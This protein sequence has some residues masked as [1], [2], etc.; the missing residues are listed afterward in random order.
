MSLQPPTFEVAG[1]PTSVRPFV[2]VKP[3]NIL[4]AVANTDFWTYVLLEQARFVGGDS[5]TESWH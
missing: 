4:K 2:G 1:V 3:Q 5:T